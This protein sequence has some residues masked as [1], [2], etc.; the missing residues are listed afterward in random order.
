M[1]SEEE[2]FWRT[3][4]LLNSTPAQI[5]V[6]ERLSG[7]SEFGLKQV[8]MTTNGIVLRKKVAQLKAAGLDQLNVSIDTLVPAKFEFITRRKGL[9]RVLEG[10]DAALQ[11]GFDT[12]KVRKAMNF[13]HKQDVRVL[14]LNRVQLTVTLSIS[15]RRFC[16]S[17]FRAS[18]SGMWQLFYRKTTVSLMQ[19]MLLISG[20]K[21]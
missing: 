9:S 18:I 10:V 13:G 4:I 12:V 1:S 14:Q 11:S 6:P 8:A 2:R 20:Q 15:H 7:L 21:V 17:Q 5:L 16:F 19:S 3:V